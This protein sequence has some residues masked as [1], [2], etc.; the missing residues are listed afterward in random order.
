MGHSKKPIIILLAFFCFMA[1]TVHGQNYRDQKKL[2]RL[3]PNNILVFGQI[4]A[5]SGEAINDATISLFDPPGAKI[6]E[7]IPV[8]DLGEYLF[9]LEM[10]KSFGLIIE[11]DGFFP[12]YTQFI[13][14]TNLEE[15]WEYAIQ[16]PKGLINRVEL[17]YN[18]GSVIP[19]NQDILEELISTLSSFT[20]LSVWVPEE[21]DSIFQLR[22]AELRNIFLEAGVESY[23]LFTGES[24]T[25]PERFI[26]LS[27]N[28]EKKTEGN[29]SFETDEITDNTPDLSPNKWTL[30]FIASKKE[31]PNSD[32]KGLDDFKLFRGKDGYFRYTYGVYNSKEEADAGKAFLKNKGFGQAFAKKIEDLQK[33]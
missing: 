2:I 13:V 11:K 27:I 22:I 10:G 31:L 32:L 20:D 5:S 26:Q 25:D 33:L 6:L 4:L 1:V 30:Q 29:D 18:Y 24:P 28:S 23:R 14:P 19:S 21:P 3:K 15:E 8:D 9:T 12:Y 7:T 17:S 16:L